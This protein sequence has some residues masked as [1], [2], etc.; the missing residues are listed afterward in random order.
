MTVSDCL[1]VRQPDNNRSLSR[2]VI[3]SWLSYRYSYVWLY[4]NVLVRLIGD[5][6][7]VKVD[8]NLV[9][10][11]TVDIPTGYKI[12]SWRQACN[13]LW[14]VSI[15]ILLVCPQPSAHYRCVVVASL[16]FHLI[17]DHKSP[18]RPRGGGTRKLILKMWLGVLF[19]EGIQWVHE[20][21]KILWQVNEDHR[22]P[23]TTWRKEWLSPTYFLS[24]S[25]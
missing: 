9:F 18:G 13:S 2:L 23:I 24:T 6:A 1:A 22:Y 4:I 21:S 19:S 11:E 15:V 25:S 16:C 7:A 8:I 10:L 5:R 17:Q 14:R 20:E 12:E 3:V